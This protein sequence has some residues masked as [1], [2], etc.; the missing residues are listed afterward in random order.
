[1]KSLFKFCLIF[2]VV[3]LIQKLALATNFNS[4]EVPM[5]FRGSMPAVEVI[6]NGEGPFLFAIDTGGQGQARAD[7]SLVE[8]LKL[9]KIGEVQAG[10]GSGKNTRTLDMVKMDS[11][12]IGDIVFSD[13]RSI[14]RNYNSSPGL[15]KIYGIL[16][17]NLF[18]NYLLTL[19]YPNKLVRIEKGKLPKA[20]GRN[21]L[22]FESP[23]GL[24]IIELSIGK[25]KVKTHI[26]SG[27]MVSG[28][29]FPTE[30][31]EKLPIIG[32][33]KVVGQARTVSNTIEIK[34]VQLRDTVRFGE[35]EFVQPKVVYPAPGSANIGSQLLGEF[36]LIF[37]QKNKRVQLKRTIIKKEVLKASNQK[38]KD[39]VGKYDVRTIFEKDGS[40]YIQREGGPELKLKEEGKDEYSL[41]R[42]P[43]A[44]IKF[45]RD[46]NGKIIEL[47]ILNPHGE[48][49]TSEKDK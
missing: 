18:E 20:N 8:R 34:Q 35:F 16:G 29:V 38:F 45:G 7:T 46:V 19:D 47:K 33:V 30:L 42:V 15:P 9:E 25:H 6:V 13:V 5:K 14:T 26:D 10:D 44:K 21:I 28:F 24:P 36:S 27:N 49:E 40:L 31:V 32:E 12:K 1:M 37:D 43:K 17:F 41:E 2:I 48:W 4:T 23:N 39:Y 11:I 22:K 3:L